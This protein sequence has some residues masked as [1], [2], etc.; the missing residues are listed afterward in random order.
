[1]FESDILDAPTIGT[2]FE[3]RTRYELHADLVVR[4]DQIQPPQ[5]VPLPV[6]FAKADLKK[7]LLEQRSFTLDQIYVTGLNC[8]GCV[9]FCGSSTDDDRQ[10]RHALAQAQRLILKHAGLPE[11]NLDMAVARHPSQS[12]SFLPKDTSY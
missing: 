5:Q 6:F 1:M 7:G 12:A 2:T 8:T 3:K 10:A 11:K 9:I 4:P